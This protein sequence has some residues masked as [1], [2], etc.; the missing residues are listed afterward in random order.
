VHCQA[1]AQDRQRAPDRAESKI[2]RDAQRIERDTPAKK[3][4]RQSGL[5]PPCGTFSQDVLP[6]N[7]DA[8]PA[9]S[10]EQDI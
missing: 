4:Q 8:L 10:S 1:G 5:F 9:R 2:K 3:L 6:L 7:L